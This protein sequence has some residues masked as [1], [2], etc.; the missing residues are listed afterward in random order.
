[1]TSYSWCPN[2]IFTLLGSPVIPLASAKMPFV[3]YKDTHANLADMNIDNIFY[4][5]LYI[6]T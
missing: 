2:C 5:R 6:F 4:I 1:M 3:I